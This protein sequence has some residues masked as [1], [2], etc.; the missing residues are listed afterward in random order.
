MSTVPVPT[1]DAFR[2]AFLA[3]EPRMTPTRR[4]LLEIHYRALHHQCTMTQISD[5]MGW[6]DYQSGN[7]HYGRLAQL[8]AQ[9]VGFRPRHDL[10]LISLCT[11]IRPQE[12]GDHYLITLRPQV[13]EALEALGWV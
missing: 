5:A 10:H 1:A 3:L 6:R 7:S 4:R 13:A 12:P 11:F 2:A 9:E 8:V